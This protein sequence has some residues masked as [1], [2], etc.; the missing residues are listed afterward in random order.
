MK[1]FNA[2]D[3]VSLVLVCIGAINWG[4]LGVFHHD[5]VSDLFGYM[6]ILARIVYVLVALSGVYLLATSISLCRKQ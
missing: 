3:W 6:T 1:A 2:V 5:L 4:I